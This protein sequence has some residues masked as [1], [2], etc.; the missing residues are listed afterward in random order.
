MPYFDWSEE[1]NEKLKEERDVSFEE[2][3][4]AVNGGGLVETID[5]PNQ[6]KHSGQKLMVVKIGGYIY[7]V[8]FVM[9]GETFFLK[10]VFPS[11]KATKKYLIKGGV[12]K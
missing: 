5:N 6:V 10:T 2:I 9:Q 8:P 3:A 7:L 4:D 1:K 12:K 11:Q